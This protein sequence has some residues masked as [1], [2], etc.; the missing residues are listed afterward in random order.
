MSLKRTLILLLAGGLI[1][2]IAVAATKL[3]VVRDLLAALL[4]FI[5]LLVAVGIAVLVSYLLG[6]VVVNCCELLQ[7]YAASF[8][9]RQQV[10]PV[11]RL[12]GS[13]DHQTV[14]SAGF[15]GSSTSKVSRIP[16]ADL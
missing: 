12:S 7:S 14:A 13:L 15:L 16:G 1:A 2:M 4:M 9:V 11:V 6:E 3:Y 10:S 8:R 5:V